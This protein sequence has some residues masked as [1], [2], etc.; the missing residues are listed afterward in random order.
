M[1]KIILSAIL[2]IGLI[3]CNDYL[4]VNTNPNNPKETTN[5][6]LIPSAQAYIAAVVGGDMYNMGGFFAQ[7]WEQAPEANQYNG[8]CEYSFDAALFNSPYRNL[9]AG[10]LKDLETVR[11]Q[12]SLNPSDYFLATV[13]RAYTFQVVVDYLDRAPYTE[14]LQGNANTMPKWDLGKDI[15]AGILDEMDKAQ[16]KLDGAS[17]LSSDV[18]LHTAKEIK[19]KEFHI[20]RWVKFANALRLKIYMRSSNVQDNSAKIKTLI[21]ENNFFEGDI[22]FNL[23]TDE[24][25]KRNPWY[26]TNVIKLANNHVGSYPIVTYLK[27]NA[28]PRLESMFKKA[29]GSGTYE[30]MLPGSKT[31]LPAKKNPAYSFPITNAIAPVYFYTQSE[32]QFFIAEAYL[33]FYNDD[34]KAKAAYQAAIDA[35]FSTRGLTGAS[36]VYDTGKAGEWLSSATIDNKLKLI[37][38][39][40][41]VALC[42]INNAE[43]WSEVRR[44]GYPALSTK[45]ASD[46]NADPSV[47]TL[48]ELIAPWANSL[49]AGKIVKCLYYPQVAI[50]LNDNTP[51]RSDLTELVWWEKK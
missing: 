36:S 47:Y 34:T 9:Y 21:D 5:E 26:E 46:I 45:K 38:V 42:M 18:M 23:F 39:Q 51:K 44:I 13:L 33:R 40:K 14:A 50:D 11:S 31:A 16:A 3:G 28:D 32:L 48:G 41:W 49:G 35:N 7:Y 30:G 19:D 24:A 22:S 20:D 27:D 12:A 8:L 43:A 29:V 25:N 37:G 15:Y 4:D 1:K 17:L 10:A 2:A 6:L